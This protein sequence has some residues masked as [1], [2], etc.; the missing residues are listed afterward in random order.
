[1][2]STVSR[3]SHAQNSARR[4]ARDISPSFAEGSIA[5]VQQP[6]VGQKLQ[7]YAPDKNG[8]YGTT[9]KGGR[10]ASRAGGRDID[11]RD[12]LETSE[13]EEASPEGDLAQGSAVQKIAKARKWLIVLGLIQPILIPLLIVIGLAILGVAVTS[14]V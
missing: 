2:P 10:G 1:M 8:G 7:E 6:Y 13:E 9:T 4:N 14:A 3:L 5:P 11:D 12:I